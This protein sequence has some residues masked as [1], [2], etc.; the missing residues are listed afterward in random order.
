MTSIDFMAL[1]KAEKSNKSNQQAS[2]H[3]GIA[4]HLFSESLNSPMSSLRAYSLSDPPNDDPRNFLYYIPNFIT[5]S[6]EQALMKQIYDETGPDHDPPPVVKKTPAWMKN[7]TTTANANKLLSTTANTSVKNDRWIS[8]SNRRLKNLGGV[9]HS[10]GLIQVPLPSYVQ[11]L[12]QLLSTRQLN[13]DQL[14]NANSLERAEEEEKQ[15]QESLWEYNQV[16]LNEYSNGKGIGFHSDGPLYHPLALVLSLESGAMIHFVETVRNDS[17]TKERLVHSVYLEPRSLLIFGGPYYYTELKH[18][19]KDG[20]QDEIT[21][22]CLN[23]ETIGKS[24][25]EQVERGSKR[26]SLTIRSCAQIEKKLEERTYSATETNEINRRANWWY[27]SINE[28]EQ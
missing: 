11:E 10:N 2:H 28:K 18:G 1:L 13:V 3:Q 7:L 16:L 15:Q 14:L 26:L 6:E 22:Q 27:N 21:D 25:G 24:V 8:L 4:H 9:P 17:E 23:R 12:K 19:I 5:E 20:M